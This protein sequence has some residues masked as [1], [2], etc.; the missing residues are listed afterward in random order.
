MQRCL[1]LAKRGLGTTYPNPMVGSVIVHNDKIIGEGWHKKAGTPHAEVN[2]INQVSNKS[3]L[4]E[5]TLYVNLEPCSHFGKTP[6]CSDLIVEY[7]IPRV[8]IASTDPNPIV[9]GRGIEKLIAAGCK[10]ETHVLQKQSDFLNRRFFTFHQK[11]RPYILL[12]WAQTKDSFIAPLPVEKNKAE[13]FW[14]SNPISKQRV[15]QWRSEEAAILVGVQ[16]I[17][18]DNPQLT[19]REWKGKNPLRLVLDP[20]A[21]VPTKS[22]VVTDKES[23]IFFTNNKTGTFSGNKKQVVLNSFSL[24]YILNYCY[25]KQIQSII[26]EGGLKTIQSFIDA[27]LWDEARVF[28]SEKRLEKGIMAPQI[29]KSFTRTEQIDSDLLSFYFN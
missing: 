14:I 27:D 1:E 21:R 3:Q 25:E 15:H 11:K 10:V 18:Q 13:I 20:N 22:I 16:T 4:K 2:A 29:K 19:T 23:T 7:G 26:V 5:S 24:D 12:K 6:P 8:V 28:S 9:S 17:V